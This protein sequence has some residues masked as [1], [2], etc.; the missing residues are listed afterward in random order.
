MDKRTRDLAL[1]GSVLHEQES[2]IL[3]DNL[4][5]PD[6]GKCEEN[7]LGALDLAEGGSRIERLGQVV[8]GEV[9][10]L[11][12]LTES[13]GDFL[14]RGDEFWVFVRVWEALLSRTRFEVVR[15][16]PWS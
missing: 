5:I 1:C 14:Q 8:V 15:I 3:L 12:E 11:L 2:K 9:A 16:R 13:L 10:V 7:L 6:S 4:F